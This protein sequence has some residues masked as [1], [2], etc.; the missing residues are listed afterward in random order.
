MAIK[1]QPVAGDHEAARR[2]LFAVEDM[3]SSSDPD[4]RAR[5]ERNYDKAFDTYMALDMAGQY[6]D[7]EINRAVSYIRKN[8]DPDLSNDTPLMLGPNRAGLLNTGPNVPGGTPRTS[9][10]PRSAAPASQAGSGNS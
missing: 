9:S 4:L 10:S 2:N 1:I 6:T 3:L 7:A 8:L 5:A